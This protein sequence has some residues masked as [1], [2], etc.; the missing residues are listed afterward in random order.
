L[1]PKV[2]FPWL[3]PQKA[4]SYLGCHPDTLRRWRRE[5]CGPRCSKRGKFIR[6]H[7]DDLD[8]WLRSL[9][10]AGNTTGSQGSKEVS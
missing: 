7:V 1:D 10:A 3:T 9:R 4:A 8:A 2:V 5:G 6:Y